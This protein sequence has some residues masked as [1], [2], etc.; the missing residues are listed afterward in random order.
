MNG[1]ALNIHN[2]VSLDNKL[3]LPKGTEAAPSATPT[4][5][6]HGFPN[7]QAGQ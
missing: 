3:I 2:I 7:P 1:K 4:Q 5:D 6:V